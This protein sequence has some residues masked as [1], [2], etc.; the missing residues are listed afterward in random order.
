M[1]FVEVPVVGAAARL[2]VLSRVFL[3]AWVALSCV[4]TATTLAQ[5]NAAPQTSRPRRVTTLAAKTPKKA[6]RPKPLTAREVRDALAQLDRLG[7]WLN[8]PA[9]RWDESARHALIAFQKVAALP[10]TGKLTRADYEALLAAERPL[11]REAGPAHIEIDLQKQVLFVVDEAGS[12]AKIL[13]ISSGNGEDFT[14]EGFER[15][16]VTPPGRFKVYNKIEGWRKS[17]LGML[18]YPSYYLSGLAVHGSPDVPPVPASHGCIRV[19]MFAAQELFALMP[20]GTPVL[21][22]PAEEPPLAQPH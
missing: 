2:S 5:T 9:L 6:P 7:Y 14:S 13:P 8:A 20:I 16:A 11:A 3:L 19:P 17:P 21:I 18:Y 4:A 1:K 22:F 15:S 10:R 12:V